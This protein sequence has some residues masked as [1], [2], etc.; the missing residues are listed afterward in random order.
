MTIKII[1]L[2][3]SS[4]SNRSAG[5]FIIFEEKFPPAQSCFGLQVN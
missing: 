4:V 2:K 1:K 5:T 3:Y